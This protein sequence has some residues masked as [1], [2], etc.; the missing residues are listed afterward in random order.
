MEREKVI[1]NLNSNRVKWLGEKLIVHIFNIFSSNVFCNLCFHHG[2]KRVRRLS[3]TEIN[4]LVVQV[5]ANRFN[6]R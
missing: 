5:E 6:E 1:K 2:S 3:I 4:T